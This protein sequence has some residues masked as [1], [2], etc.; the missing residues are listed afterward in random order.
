MNMVSFSKKAAAIA[1]AVAMIFTAA[2][3]AGNT[4]AYADE[5]E[6]A[7]I[8]DTYVIDGVTYYN[9]G[10]SAFATKNPARFYKELLGTR[11]SHL[12]NNDKDWSLSDMWLG[13]CLGLDYYTVGRS[14]PL[15]QQ[16]GRDALA[17]GEYRDPDAPDNV[18]G[19]RLDP[20]EYGSLKEA[21]DAM[22]NSIFGSSVS[23]GYF[24]EKTGSQPVVASAIMSRS[25]SLCEA[26]VVYFSNFRVAPI[27]PEDKDNNYVTTV[28]KNETNSVDSAASAIKND[29]SKE[30][31]ARQSV[32]SSTL[33]SAASSIN[34][35]ESYSYSESLKVGAEYSFT[36]AFKASME[37]GFTSTQAVQK[38][39]GTSDA[40]SNTH[41]ATHEVD[42]NLPPYTQGY[43][44]QKTTEA[45]NVTRYNCPIALK[46]DATI[47]FYCSDRNNVPAIMPS[48]K[49]KI[50]K[51][52]FTFTDQTNGA[53]G[54]LIQRIDNC[55]DGVYDGEG[56]SWG[57]ELG[58]T[59]DVKYMTNSSSSPLKWET[60]PI[61]YLTAFVPMSPTGAQFRETMKVVS[62]EVREFQPL[63]PLTMIRIAEPP[64]SV[65]SDEVNWGK[66]SYYTAKMN[67]GDHSYA[68]YIAL[69]GL[70]DK[71]GA[72][73][74]FNKNNGYWVVTDKDG[75]EL[76]EETAPVKLEKDPV[77]S[78]WR[79]TA[80]RPGTCFLVYRINEDVY[81]TAD[82]PQNFIKNED[83]K[84]T[85][86]LE[87]IVPGKDANPMKLSPKTANVK[88]SKL[89]KK[90]QTL[91]A[92]KVIKFTRDAKDKK[93]Y[94]L[95]SAKKG[96]KSFKKYF[97][98]NKTTGKVT[99][100]KGLKKGTYKVRIKVRAKG[101]RKYLPSA[102]KSVTFKVIVR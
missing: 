42:V 52:V 71:N 80:V 69:E 70:N 96:S 13:M 47:V 58:V 84:K 36:P 76:D 55:P 2:P 79:Y 31:S 93:T 44:T 95:V 40:L 8:Q 66:Y 81:A 30:I 57:K 74:Q 98:I 33:V 15:I 101:N 92:R 85:A 7:A 4:A 5:Q 60:S 14:Y 73:Y 49:E 83:L 61:D 67:V 6:P 25:F 99:V 37:L 45:E 46:Y 35:S 16:T 26:V 50:D 18:Y 64:Q 89:K 75:K 87:I 3:F 20:A 43:I 21:E 53:R 1:I 23:D 100:R 19:K 63:Y 34:G 88:Y 51:M 59:S 32:T 97:R 86:A 102:A 41:S 72:Y 65:I 56:L 82:E 38:G 62:S 22:T 24:K 9:T 77:S 12:K 54:D 29:T 11:T 27:M 68:N 17:Q 10:S 91:A 78:N 94:A 90:N 39:W 48:V 28:V